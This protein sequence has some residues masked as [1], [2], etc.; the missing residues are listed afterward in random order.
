[1]EAGSQTRKQLVQ[2]KIK[3]GCQIYKIEDYVAGTGCFNCSRFN[4]KFR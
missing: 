2:Q 1:M 4:D 3:L